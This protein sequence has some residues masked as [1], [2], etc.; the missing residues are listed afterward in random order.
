MAGGFA[1]VSL[2]AHAMP[3]FFVQQNL[4]TSNQAVLTGLGYGAAA[5]VDT[6]LV[7]PWGI[8]HSATSPFWVSNNG[9]NLSTLYNTTGVKQGLVVTI[10]GPPTG[11]VNNIGGAN[12]FKVGGVKSNFIFAT[13]DGTI[14]ARASGTTATTMHTTP[15]AVYKGLAIGNNGS[16]VFL[17]AANFN[18]GK[19]DVFDNNFNPVS[20]SGSFNDAALPAGYAPFNVQ[21][22]NGKLYVTY[23]L[24]DALKKDD[25]AGPGNGFVS[26]FDLNGNF[27]ARVASGGTLNSPWGLDIAPAGF[28]SFANDLL[29]GNF[30]DGTINVFDPITNAFLGQL[31]NAA[32]IP[33]ML[34]GLWALINGNGG[35]GGNPNRV[36][37]TAGINGEQDGLFGSLQVPEP[38]SLPLLGAGLAV[39]GLLRWRKKAEFVP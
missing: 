28:G 22:L 2:P 38:G 36:Y 4:V 13:E 29:V 12:D 1:L 14:A 3:S 37:F 24:Q 26:V 30:G 15:G 32:G 10:P 9:T 8:S 17:Y 27:L 34:D 16:G 18:S 5:H 6:S 39:L 33:F 25:V 23:A 35:N 11:Q 21:T 20:L 19:V 7:N 31:A